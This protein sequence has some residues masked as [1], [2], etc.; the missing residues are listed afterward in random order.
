[1]LFDAGEDDYSEEG[2]GDNDGNDITRDLDPFRKNSTK[3]TR[4]VH[5]FPV[6][7]RLCPA[8]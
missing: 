3:S 8:W 1:M 7:V 6:R 2:E 5:L 4:G